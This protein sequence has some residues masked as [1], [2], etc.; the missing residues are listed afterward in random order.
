MKIKN[1][2]NQQQNKI[3]K[4]MQTFCI[5]LPTFNFVI[6]KMFKKIILDKKQQKKVFFFYKIFIF[7]KKIC[8]K[9]F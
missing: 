3:L 6:F 1:K 2:N 4:Y 9:Y 5:L 7:K 8:I